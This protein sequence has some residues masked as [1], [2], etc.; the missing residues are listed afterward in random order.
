MKELCLRLGIERN[1]STA[2]HPQTDGQTKQTNQEMEQYLRLYISYRQDDWT[3]WLPIAEFAHN[4]WIHSSTGKSLFFINLGRH[5]NTGKEIRG[6]GE[7]NPSVDEF[8]EGMSHMRKEVEVALKKTNEV[9]KQKFD[10][11]KGPEWQ[12]NTGDLVWVDG[13]HYNTDRPSR[14]LA[15]KRASPFPIMRK[16]ESA[17]YELKI[18]SDWKH[19]HPVIYE[20]YLKPYTRPTFEQQQERSN[21]TVTPMPGKEMVLEVEE[22][23]DSRWRNDHLQYLIEWRGQPWEER[24][25]EDRNN[26]LEGARQLCNKFHKEHPDAPRIPAIRIPGR[27]LSEVARTRS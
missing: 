1:P 10:S 25:W 24:T 9:M 6:L 14:K 27:L 20:S 22:V 17:A 12:F 26:I 8:L 5:P 15:F 21:S 23:L 16:V 13:T 18:P 19:I 2:Y 3:E 4:N 11:N 7:K